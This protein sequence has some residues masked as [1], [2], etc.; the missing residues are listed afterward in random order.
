MHQL[1]YL[2][3]I[4]IDYHLPRERK[5][6]ILALSQESAVPP[7]TNSVYTAGYIISEV[8]TLRYKISTLRTANKKIC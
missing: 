3:S 6:L 2:F 5:L 1:F 8:T 7:A 4:K